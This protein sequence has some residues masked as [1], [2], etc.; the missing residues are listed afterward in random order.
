MLRLL[1]AHGAAERPLI[2]SITSIL[3]RRWRS[4]RSCSRCASMPS[5]LV[6]RT[7]VRCVC[8]TSTSSATLP[9]WRKRIC[10]TTCFTSSST[11]GHQARKAIPLAWEVPGR[12]AWGQFD[13]D[14]SLGKLQGR[15]VH[16]RNA[17]RAVGNLPIQSTLAARA[18]DVAE[19]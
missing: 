4:M 19:S 18:E 6:T 9:P 17:V 3:T 15:P 11:S 1:A 7:T 5:A 16:V 2:L 14:L 10:A 12:S 8:C 13:S